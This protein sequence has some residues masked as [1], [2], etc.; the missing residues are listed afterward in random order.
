MEQ[1]EQIHA[2]VI[3]SSFLSNVVV[4]TALLN[5][6]SKCESID[7]AS[8]SFVE[9][10]TRT[11]VSWTSMIAAFAQNGCSE[12]ALQLFEDMRFVGGRPNLV[13]FTAV[14][15]V[16]S[17]ARMVEEAFAYFNMMK[18]KYRIKPARDHYSCLISMYARLVTITAFSKMVGYTLKAAGIHAMEGVS[19]EIIILCLVRPLDRSTIN[20]SVRETNRLVIVEESLEYPDAPVERN[21]SQWCEEILQKEAT[22]VEICEGFLSVVLLCLILEDKDLSIPVTTNRITAAKLVAMNSILLR[23]NY[24]I[25]LPSQ[26]ALKCIQFHCVIL[27]DKDL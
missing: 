22:I 8:R 12:Q 27:G 15:F 2:Q 4:G 17:H 9:M 13:T 3:K 5:M 11:L 16:C 19:A 1:G 25:G 21:I 7:S 20:A 26:A 18:S 10:S 24:K 6:Y 23:E 14:L